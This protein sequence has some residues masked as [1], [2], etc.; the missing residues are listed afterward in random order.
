MIWAPRLRWTVG[1]AELCFANPFLSSIC[2]LCKVLPIVRGAGMWQ[3]MMDEVVARLCAPGYDNWV[4]IFPE[5]RVHQ[6]AGEM[7]RLKWGVGRLV[8][9]PPITPIVLPMYIEGTKK[10]LDKNRPQPKLLSSWHGE[11]IA[12]YIGEPIDLSELVAEAKQEAMNA[13]NAVDRIKTYRRVT[14]VIQEKMQELQRQAE[15]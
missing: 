6:V 7:R 12:I 2:Y 14:S 13:P 5:G 4:H 3:P 10:L 1:A 8:A 9:D 15:L 11:R